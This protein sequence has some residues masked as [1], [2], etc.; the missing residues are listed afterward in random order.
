MYFYNLIK[1]ISKNKKI[2][3]FVDMDGVIASY[4]FGKPL[5]FKTK[6]PLKSSIRTLEK[7]SKMNN[8]ELY[9]LSIC[10]KDTEINDK[11]N[12]LDQHA[13]FFKKNNR[14]IL[15]KE[16]IPDQTSGK[17]KSLFLKYYPSKCQKV[18]VDDDNTVLKE[19][20]KENKDIILLQDSELID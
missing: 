6:R 12:W 5:N 20:R 19:I 7:V 2:A 13:P 9:I 1:Q 17:M 16:T 3:L 18:L 10:K 4:D 14:Y 15:S 11:N 8:V